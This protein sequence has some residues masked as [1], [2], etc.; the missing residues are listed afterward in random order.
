MKKWF[1]LILI[2]VLTAAACA[3]EEVV[4]E[5]APSVSYYTVTLSATMDNE[6]PESKTSY[7][8][9]KTFSWSAGDQISV[10]FNN[11]ETNKFFT[12]TTT[13]GGKTASFTG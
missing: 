11:G 6:D 10:L 9:D 4:N 3:R 7:T 8:N 2:A 5:T 12:F 13:E 1:L